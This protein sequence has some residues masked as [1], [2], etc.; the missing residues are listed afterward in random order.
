LTPCILTKTLSTPSQ[1]R[2]YLLNLYCLPPS[3]P[4]WLATITIICT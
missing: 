1:H 2:H 4:G 3:I